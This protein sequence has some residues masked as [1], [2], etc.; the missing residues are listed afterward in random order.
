MTISKK[1]SKALLLGALVLA[2]SALIVPTVQATT[3]YGVW[4][5]Y[6]ETAALVEI[7]GTKVSCPGYPDQ[8]DTAADGT[9]TETPYF[10]T[11]T[12]VCP[13]PSG[14]GGGGGGG[15]EDEEAPPE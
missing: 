8:I 3:C 12:V 14:S 9:Y 13:C 1:T 5:D 10:T 7:V 11:E 15:G 6:F 4:Y 2:C